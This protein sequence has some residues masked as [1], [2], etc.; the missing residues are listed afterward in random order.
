MKFLIVL[1]A[2]VSLSVG[3]AYAQHFEF[4]CSGTGNMIA[5]DD[6]VY[7]GTIDSGDLAPGHWWMEV[8]DDGWPSASNPQLRWAYVWDN[9][10]VYDPGAQVWTGIFDC[11]LDLEHTGYG[12][13][14]GV[15]DLTFQHIDL[16]GDMN[17]D[18]EECANGL[19]GAVII[20]NE[21]TGSYADLCGDGNYQGAFFRVCD[22]GQDWMNDYVDFDMYLDL[23]ECGLAT[24][25]STWAS[26]KALFR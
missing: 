24:E 18:P 25:Q 3:A 4:H 9:Y 1:A 16:D 21:G 7:S 26:V 17:L 20:I 12:T 19:S 22:Q 6:P 5:F 23:E 15:C 8:N 2:L 13:M 10:Y 11:I 14:H